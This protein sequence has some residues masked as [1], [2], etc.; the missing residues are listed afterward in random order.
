MN[1][2][3][4]KIARPAKIPQTKSA[5]QENST[6]SKGGFDDVLTTVRDTVVENPIRSITTT[7]SGLSAV[8]TLSSLGAGTANANFSQGASIVMGAVHGVSGLVRGMD[9]LASLGYSRTG[10]VGGDTKKQGI[11]AI[12]D[13][14]SAAGQFALAGGVTTPAAVLI[15][16]GNAIS[17]MADFSS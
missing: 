7:A 15:V 11:S 2:Q 3:S 4:S 1:I 8:G 5:P 14:V 12:G 9:S 6:F 10:L 16:G 13:L 17:A